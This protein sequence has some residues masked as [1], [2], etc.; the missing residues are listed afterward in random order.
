MM[1]VQIDAIHQFVP[2]L[3]PRDA[4]G[5]H[6]L[7]M[8][9]TFREAGL[10]SEV[11]AQA[12]HPSIRWKARYYKQFAGDDRAVLLYH[13]GIGSPVADFVRARGERRAVYHHNVTP[14]SMIAPWDPVAG[15]ALRVGRRQVGELTEGAALAMA[16][17]RYSLDEVHGADATAVV[18]ILFDHEQFDRRLDARALDR[19]RRDAKHAGSVWLFVGRIS[20]NKAQHDLVSAFAMHRR[21]LD[22]TALLRIVGGS[23]AETYTAALRRHI[24]SLGLEDAVSIT[25]SVSDGELAAHYAAADVF[26][27]LSDHEG[28]CVPLVE[29]MHRGLPVVAYAAAAV[30][31][32]LG[33]GGLL[34]EDKRPL[35]VAAAVQAV[36]GDETTRRELIDAGTR[37]VAE[38]SLPRARAALTGALEE[39]IGPGSMGPGRSSGCAEGPRLGRQ[40]IEEPDKS[41]EESG[42]GRADD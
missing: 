8:R 10:R 30:P 35:T 9:R 12:V 20:P 32:T 19:L 40:S 13:T 2:V 27:C 14:A 36:L 26:V 21:E 1:G 3:A 33:S 37:R 41:T 31:E 38:L 22:P 24:Q 15:A 4:I 6:L 29:A 16:A 7:E 42:R 17:S 23:A 18:P 11:Y 28:F 39:I 34:L 25:G 5:G